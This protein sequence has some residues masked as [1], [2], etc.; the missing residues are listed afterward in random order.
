MHTEYLGFRVRAPRT[1]RHFTVAV[2]ALT[3]GLSMRHHI[4]GE[5][6]ELGLPTG[7]NHEDQEWTIFSCGLAAL[8]DQ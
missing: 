5:I 8:V 4:D 3:D 2:T 6:H 1:V 7:P